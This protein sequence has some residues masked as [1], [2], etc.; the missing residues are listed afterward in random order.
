MEFRSSSLKMQYK[1]TR[2]LQKQKQEVIGERN[3][4]GNRKD[5][6]RPLSQK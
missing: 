1:S 4:K 5:E 2:S 3:R 6:G